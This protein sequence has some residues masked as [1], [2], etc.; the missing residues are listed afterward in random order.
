LADAVDF[1]PRKR[2]VVDASAIRDNTAALVRHVGPDVQVMAMVKSNGYG[3]G[4]RLAADAAIDGGASWLGVAS[5]V[6][7]LE[8]VATG[9]RVLIV[10]RADPGSHDALLA[11]GVHT[12]VYDREGIDVS[13]AAARRVGTRARVHL[14]V[15][16]GMGRLG[17][18]P[19]EVTEIVGALGTRADDLE[20]VGVFTNFADSDAPDFSYTE[21][22]H[23]C[24]LAA[25]AAVRAVAPH[26]LAHC[27][28]SGAILRAPHMHHDVVR[29]GLALYGY[30]PDV[31]RDVVDLRIAM[32]MVA[33]VTQVKTVGA[34]T[35]VGYGRTWT[36]TRTTRVATIA[37]GYADGVLRAQSN[38]GVVLIGGCRRPIVGRVSMDQLCVD[39]GDGREGADEV[40]P[41]DDAV[42]FGEQAGVRLGADEVG[43]AAGTIE[44]EVLT[45]VPDRIPR[46]VSPEG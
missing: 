30:A 32:T 10:G 12:T 1:A 26:A 42:L 13:A 16:T 24:F 19:D 7:A 8:L 33:P 15:D 4:L 23:D 21:R 6:E 38:R 5:S 3:H 41:G 39:L 29:P 44:R 35:P 17:V 34:G 18:Q 14:K 43:A 28:N 46:V 36:A 40:R 31:A 9:A 20:L 25:V 27:S 37:A 22:Q 2:V 45:A 11:A